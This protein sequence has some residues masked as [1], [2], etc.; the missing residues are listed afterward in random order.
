[1]DKKIIFGSVAVATLISFA[2]GAEGNGTTLKKEQIE[3][4][5]EKVQKIL[6]KVSPKIP[7]KIKLDNIIP[8]KGG[9]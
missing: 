5:K 4:K 9:K 8:P 7:V 1:M 2:V 3:H 6:E